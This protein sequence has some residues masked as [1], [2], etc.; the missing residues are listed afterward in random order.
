MKKQTE[1]DIQSYSQICTYSENFP[2]LRVK[3]LWL[4]RIS[5]KSVQLKTIF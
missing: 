1:S 5:V 3:G 4:S 2:K